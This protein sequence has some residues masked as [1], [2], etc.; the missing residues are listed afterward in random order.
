MEEAGASAISVLTEPAYFGGSLEDLRVVK[1]SV[2]I[3]V[4]RK[5]F[6]F[7]EHQLH[8]TVVYGADAVLLI[9]TI[10][11]EKTTVF[12]DK[13]QELGLEVLVE[14]HSQ[15]DI[16]YAI[17]SNTKLIGINN[18]NLKTLEVDIGA[19][20][21]LAPQIPKYKTIVSESGIKAAD[22]ARRAKK[23]GAKAI[24]CGTAISRSKNIAQKI[25][26]LRV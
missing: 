14:I 22:D 24:L 11:K 1:E 23:A 9:A 12:V 15:A 13:A 8:E 3:P 16:E 26:E 2:G 4:M 10:L 5:D 19:T 6:I 18:R 7:S 17:D 25:K 20:E 21:R